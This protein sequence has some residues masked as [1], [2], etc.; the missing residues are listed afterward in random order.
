MQHI[1]LREIIVD[2]WAS[3]KRTL[4]QIDAIGT[5]ICLVASL[6]V[7][8]A[9]LNPLIKQRSFLADQRNKLAVQRDESSRLSASMLTLDNQLA[10]AQEE[11]ADGKIRLESSDRTNQRLAALTALFT[12]FSLAVD[13]IQASTIS[14]GPTWDLVPISIAGR[15]EY[16]QCV[17]FLHKL[18][19]TFADMTVVRLRLE[20]DPAKSDKSGGF[21]FQLLWHTTPKAQMAKNQ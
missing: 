13:N 14:T 16:T 17:A 21:R 1:S 10:V 20:G 19:Q 8:F 5:V 9:V 11:L 15:G 6:A 2:L 7:Y 4:Q 18:R 3:K 12:D